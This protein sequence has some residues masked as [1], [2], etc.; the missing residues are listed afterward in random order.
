[1]EIT[2]AEETITMSNNTLLIAEFQQQFTLTA[3]QNPTV[4]GTVTPES[5]TQH[6]AN[7]PF[8]IT[9]TPNNGYRF[10][11][12]TV[13]T[14]G[15]ATVGNVNNANTTV[16]LHANATIR[17]NFQQVCTL[18]IERNLTNGGTVTPASGQRYDANTPVNITANPASG[19]RFVNWTVTSGTAT[20]GSA[21]N[22]STTVRLSTDATV[23]ANFQ[24]IFTLTINRAVEG[25]ISTA[26]G[27]V[28]PASGLNHDAP[29]PDGASTTVN[30]TA[31]VNSGYRFVNWTVTSGTATFGNAGEASTTVTLSSNATIQANF[32]RLST[33][34]IERNITVGG[35]VTPESGLIYDANTPIS[36]TATPTSSAYIFVNWR[37]I[38]GTI[39]FGDS[40][41]AS[42]TVTLGSNATIRANFQQV[43]RVDGTPL[44]DSRDG[45]TYRTVIIGDQTWMAENLN[46]NASGSACYNNSP[47]SCAK[48][49]RLYDWAAV[50]AGSPS[51]STNPSDVQ[52]ICPPGWH[53]PSN[54]EWTVLTDVVGGASTAGTLLKSE[55]DWN[56]TDNLGF[57]ALPGGRWSGGSF[58]YVGTYGNWWS[59]TEHDAA[60]ARYR[61]MYSDDSNV[62]TNWYYKTS[63]FSLRCAQD[64]AP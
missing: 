20:F 55:T 33:L 27:T 17:A 16:N 61:L 30:I 45:Q 13:V 42:T 23:R 26:G 35:T 29:T 32:H 25:T 31:T 37:R 7:A 10:V 22:A 43:G 46:Y 54:A 4:G 28:T 6:D 34:T 50:M 18:T 39:T 48:Y 44:V 19:Y 47:D 38:S 21:T 60:L 24:R 11:D 12:W 58:G 59:A 2:N 62:D 8:N 53:V 40:T 9:A 52:G 5:G 36:I 49:G 57:S 56:G 51:S 14:E 1:L 15:A 63:G 3:N 41:N 64:Y